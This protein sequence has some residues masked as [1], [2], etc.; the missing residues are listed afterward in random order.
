M[1]IQKAFDWYCK[2]VES[3]EDHSRYLYTLVCQRPKASEGW[4]DDEGDAVRKRR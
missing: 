4:G 1:F 2:A 3:T